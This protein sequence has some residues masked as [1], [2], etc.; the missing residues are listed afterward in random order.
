MDP[1]LNINFSAYGASFI[2]QN[3]ASFLKPEQAS[4]E[5]ASI[6][7]TQ[8]FKEALQEKTQGPDALYVQ[9][10]ETKFLNDFFVEQ[11]ARELIDSGT[12]GF[13]DFMPKG[14]MDK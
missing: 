6:F 10:Q 14:I 2:N 1:G 3:Y 8:L 9:N 7:L 11:V 12:F 13:S 5:F 4:Q